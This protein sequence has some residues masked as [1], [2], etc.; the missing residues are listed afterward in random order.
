MLENR[1][2]ENLLNR[3][4]KK[5]SEEQAHIKKC[6]EIDKKHYHMNVE[7][8]KLIEIS[9][10][11]K[12]ED[13]S[14]DIDRDVILIHN[15]NPYITYILAIKALYNQIN[16]KICINEVMLGTNL[17]LVK[18]IN[19]IIKELE[20]ENKIEIEKKFTLELIEKHKSEKIV[21]LGD[22]EPYLELLKQ[23]EKNVYYRPKYNVA[24]YVESQQLE[25]LKQNII[26]YC[27][28]NF[29]EIEIY[30]V[31]NVKEA[32]EQMKIDNEGEKIMLLTNEKIDEEDLKGID[33]S[34]NEN[35]LKNIEERI[36]KEKIL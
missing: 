16:M 33:V 32:I 3:L 31:E 14:E 20:I 8:S 28:N 9:K 25:E 5:I 29:I 30:E 27:Y 13:L 19:E 2:K 36:I 24:M 35:I 12:K 22:K 23:R 10:K 26:N 4:I 15:G 11:L 6:N 17:I 1:I 18:I 34:I 7:I 21:V